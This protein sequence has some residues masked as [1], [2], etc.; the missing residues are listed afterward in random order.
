MQGHFRTRFPTL[1]SALII[2]LLGTM[3]SAQTP[4]LM[5]DAC[6]RAAQTYFHDYTAK[7]NMTYNG[8]RTDGTQAINGRI[9]LETR[10]EDVACSFDRSGRQMVEFFA[11]GQ[12]QPAMVH[13]STGTNTTVTGVSANDILNVRSGP[14]VRYKV[15]GALGNGSRVR[16]LD[17]AMQG[18]ARWCQIEMLTDMRERGWVNARYLSTGAAVQQPSPPAADVG[19]TTTER[20]RFVSGT[21]GAELSGA[22]PPGASRRYELGASAR[23]MLN[24][25]LS[26]NRSGLSYQIFNPDRSSLV[27]QI[28]ASQPY[29]GQLW[30]TGDHVIEVINRSN[31]RLNYKVEVWIR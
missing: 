7:S 3:S 4:S 8:T 21:S 18:N 11:E 1:W 13:T 12:Y 9:F 19:G 15:V 26:P 20:V 28:P 31:R 24:V 10:F 6:A 22:L 25:R 5:Q 2:S 14:G 30:Q 16:M 23:Q 29:R 27:S 17:C